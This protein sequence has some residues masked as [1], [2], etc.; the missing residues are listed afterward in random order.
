MVDFQVGAEGCLHFVEG[1]FPAV[2]DV[3]AVHG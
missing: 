1:D 2:G 3:A